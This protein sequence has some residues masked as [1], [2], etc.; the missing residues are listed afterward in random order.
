MAYIELRVQFMGSIKR[1]DLVRRFGIKH[2]AAS[3]DL[4]LYTDIAPANLCYWPST[5]SY[6][7][8][9][10][11]RPLFQLRQDRVISWLLHG[12][13]DGV[14]QTPAHEFVAEDLS[15]PLL[16]DTAVLSTITTAL[17]ARR[18]LSLALSGDPSPQRSFIATPTALFKAG[19][20]LYVR[21]FD[22]DRY[23]HLTLA[24]PAIAQAAPAGG[25]APV[26]IALPVDRQWQDELLLDLRVHPASLEPAL[27]EMS[28]G[29]LHGMRH[30]KARAA[31]AGYLLRAHAVDCS[32]HQSLPA[33]SHPL[34]LANRCILARAESACLAPGFDA[35]P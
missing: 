15:L 6:H 10:D 23:D 7:P 16:F 26:R 12:Y 4:S 3:R 14:D 35:H 29:L 28:H 27:V 5:K 21:V 24:L 17:H 22:E 34:Y 8:T 31:T 18:A 9:S 1:N 30:V 20:A 13:G 32:A 25:V 11:F 19:T 2:A 33:A